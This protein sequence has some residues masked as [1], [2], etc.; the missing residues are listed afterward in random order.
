MDVL[1]KNRPQVIREAGRWISSNRETLFSFRWCSDELGLD[2]RLVRKK[3][4]EKP[5]SGPVTGK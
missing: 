4:R 5:P 3:I 2:F 1:L